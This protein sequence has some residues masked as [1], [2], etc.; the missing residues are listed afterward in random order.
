MIHKEYDG[1]EIRC[2]HLGLKGRAWLSHAWDDW[3]YCHVDGVWE[4][5]NKAHGILCRE[6]A[7][8]IRQYLIGE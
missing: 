3:Y 7:H 5:G 8:T 6:Q 1:R 2:S 4:N